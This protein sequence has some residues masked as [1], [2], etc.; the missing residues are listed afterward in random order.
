MNK[1]FVL[2]AFLGLAASSSVASWNKADSL[3]N[4]PDFLTLAYDLEFDFGYGSHYKGT[5]PA[6]DMQA[7]TY[8]VHVY[9]YAKLTLTSEWFK[10]YHHVAEIEFVPL[11][12]APYEHTLTWERVDQTGAFHVYNT[13]ARN[14]EMGEFT[15]EITENM[16]TFEV[17]VWD[18]IDDGRDAYPSNADKSYDDEY[19][20][21]YVDPYYSFNLF[22]DVL[23][24]NFGS[25]YGYKTYFAGKKLF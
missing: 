9:S 6:S 4:E 17:S 15:V 18:V 11:Y 25:W 21:E 22:T 8:G 13:G 2:A 20:H 12:F 1:A 14:L 10:H 16:K 19:E 3:V 23:D 7:E 24:M 5:D